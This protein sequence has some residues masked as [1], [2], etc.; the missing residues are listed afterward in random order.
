M[1]SLTN[2]TP[3]AEQLGIIRRTRAGVELIR[4]A[5]GSGKTTTAILKLKLL[6]LWVLARRKRDESTVPV[7]ALVLTYNKTLKGYIKELVKNNTPTGAVEITVDTFSRW[8]I[9]TLGSPSIY[10]GAKLSNLCFAAEHSVG[11]P[12]DFLVNEVQYILGRFRPENLTD[13]LNQTRDGRGAAPRVDKET[14]QKILD[15]I[16]LPFQAYKKNYGYMDWNDIAV[17]MSR[18]QYYNYDIVIVDE[19]Q[20]FSAN[21]IRAL[22]TQTSEETATNIVLDTAQR[23]YSNAFTWNEVGVRIRPENS[24]RLSV[25]Y[26]NT[27]EIAHLASSLINCVR[28]DDDGTAP[29]LDELQGNTKS[30]ILKGIFRE[31]VAWIIDHIKNNIDTTKESVAFLHPKGWFSFLEDELTK[32]GIE[33]V[34][35][36]KQ[37]EWPKS[38][39]NV[40]LSTLHSAKGLDF[41]HCFMLGL[42]VKN[43]PEGQHAQ[44]DDRFDNACR[45]LSMA[46]ARA[47]MSVILGYKPGEEPAILANLN[48]DYYDEI[49]L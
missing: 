7:K 43:L 15:E 1:K 9:L 21:Q 11:L 4:G 36:T 18:A 47:R 30:I 23:I 49:E 20:D 5:A 29:R 33:Y 22:L 27:P 39:V 42:A 19:A 44:G 35:L 32:A 2:V 28:L 41:D 8:A 6:V 40:A 26:R 34:S 37:S 31:Q 45:L 17:D 16:V 25:N 46:I 12:S 10:D 38:E 14:R 24:H 3:S 48:S 13:Y